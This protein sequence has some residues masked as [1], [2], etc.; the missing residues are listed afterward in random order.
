MAGYT[1]KNFDAIDNANSDP[2]IAV[3]ARFARK[4]LEPEHLGPPRL[5]DGLTDRW[6]RVA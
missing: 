1:I 4:Q 2:G 3:D 5:V 6:W